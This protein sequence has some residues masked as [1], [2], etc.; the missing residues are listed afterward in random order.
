MSAI[1]QLPNGNL[2]LTVR[3]TLVPGRDDELIKLIQNAPDR[4]MAATIREAMR[5]GCN[6]MNGVYL[7]D[8]S[9][10]M[11]SLGYDV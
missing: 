10:D 11:G 9:L 7:E 4:G 8:D 3:I 5:T 1:V 2:I 6:S